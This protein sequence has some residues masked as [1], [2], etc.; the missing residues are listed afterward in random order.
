LQ[1]LTDDGS[2][3]SSSFTS[4]ITPKTGITDVRATTT[5]SSGSVYVVG[6][7]TG[8]LGAGEV[9]AEQDVYLR[10]YDGAGQLVW[11]RLLGSSDSATGYAV[12]TDS[13]GN[14][15]I[16]G[17]TSDKLTAKAVGGGDDSFVTKFDSDGREIFTRQ[18]SP[19][20]D[21]QA[22]A[23][24]FGSDGSLYVAGQT[25]SAMN[26]SVTANGGTDAYLM[27]L[28]STGSLDYVRQFGSSGEDLATALAVD[29]NGDVVVGTMESGAATIHKFSA[30][31]GS[32]PAVWS[33]SLGSLGQGMLSSVVVDGGAVYAG[34]ST[35]NTSLDAGGSAS[36][37]T[38]HSGGSDGFVMKISDQ[39]SSA[40]AQFTSYAGTS[41]TDSGVGLAVSNGSVYIAGSTSGS[42][43]GGMA[44]EKTNAF[45]RKLDS[46]G[47]TVWTHQYEGTQGTAAARSV[48]VDSQGGSVLDRLGLP[49][50][51]ISFDETRSVTAGSSVRAGDHFYVKVNEGSKLKVTVDA[52]DT[53]RSL[54]RK[55]SNLLLLKGSA[56]VSRTGGDGI[57]IT[58]KEG[59]TIELIAGSEGL[60][61]LAGLGIDPVRLD[62]N[63]KSAATKSK[64]FSLG[65]KTD[66]AIGEKLKAN[67]VTYQ[68]GTAMEVIKNA[69]L[70]LSVPAKAAAPQAPVTNQRA[71]ASYQTAL[72][73]L[74][75]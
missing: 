4:K 22:N 30:A 51:E 72:A 17:K 33:L 59:N 19:R 23:L 65:L 34:G 35:T 45:I 54:A 64:S 6:T 36:I 52:G 13:S 46:S 26:S 24:A 47:A 21:D 53:M 5:D 48:S 70:H 15:A 10:K 66:V 2:S 62:A 67:T 28:S 71:L 12:A 14:V 3:V 56:E 50:G 38:V 49:R 31:D 61:A 11:S 63:K 29:S 25:D 27:K 68:L 20:S 1:K 60:D 39:G 44:P 18:I 75:G 40:A 16:A 69:Y 58:A 57:R 32:S 41:G 74:G 42:L 73:A 8:D 43:S 7:A 9:Q 55:V 37:A